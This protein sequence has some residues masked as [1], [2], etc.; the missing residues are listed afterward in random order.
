MDGATSRDGLWFIAF[1]GDAAL[2]CV[3]WW[4][5]FLR[6]GFRH[7][8]A[9]QA[10]G[11]GHTLVVDFRGTQMRVAVEPVPIGVFLRCMQDA[12]MSWI[13]AVEGTGAPPRAALRPPMTCVETC[14]ALLGIR[15]W[16]IIT[17]RQLARHL[18]KKGGKPVLPI[19]RGR[20]TWPES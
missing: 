12:A 19:T 20:P 18:H 7:C 8:L 17:P 1:P 2:T 14:K 9:C 15:A 10:A 6:G 4:A 3:P 13:I 5:R 16:W 11:D